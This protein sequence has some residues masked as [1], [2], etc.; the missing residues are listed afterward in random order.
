M[1]SAGA[2]VISAIGA[3]R[4]EAGKDLARDRVPRAPAIVEVNIVLGR[5]AR[6]ET[7]R[8]GIRRIDQTALHREVLNRA[9]Q[10]GQ[11]Q[12][13]QQGQRRRIHS[14]GRDASIGKRGRRGGIRIEYYDLLACQRTRAKAGLGKVSLPLQLCWNGGQDVKGIPIPV[15]LVTDEPHAR[16]PHRPGPCRL[17][18]PGQGAT[19]ADSEIVLNLKRL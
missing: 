8:N 15:P 10:V 9:R 1:N 13:F 12:I 16:L 6:I 7:S 11:R 2:Q 5:D 3:I 17:C 19:D 18:A 4:I 14:V